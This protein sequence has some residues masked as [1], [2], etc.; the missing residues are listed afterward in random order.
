M[1]TED[2]SFNDCSNAQII[3][4]FSAVFPG[5]SVTI[6]SDSFIIE[7]INSGNLSGF[8]V[9]SQQCDVCRIFKL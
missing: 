1:N 2:F 3:K 9:S 8:V 5:I 4:D 7:T 6:L